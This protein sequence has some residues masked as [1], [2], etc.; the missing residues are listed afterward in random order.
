MTLQNHFDAWSGFGMKLGTY[1][2]QVM[3]VESWS[4]GGSAQIS[5]SKG[6]ASG[7]SGGSG[8]APSSSTAPT[9]TAKPTSAAPT[10]AAPTSAPTG[11]SGVAPKYGQCGGQGWTGPTTCAAGS[12]CK[13]SNQW[14]SQCL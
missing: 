9:A 2:F 12:T 10:S 5:L 13:A 1:N 11:G 8:S 3:A 6:A 14:Y 4:G 7:G